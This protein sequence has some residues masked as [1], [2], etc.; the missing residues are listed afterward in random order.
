MNKRSTFHVLFILA[1]GLTL[2]LALFTPT[3][4]HASQSQ[5]D[6]EAWRFD[7]RLF[8]G[9]YLWYSGGWTQ[10]DTGHAVLTAGSIGWRSD[11]MGVYLNYRLGFA[12]LY[13][14]EPDSVFARKAIG[15]S[16]GPR[17]F[18]DEGRYKIWTQVSFAVGLYGHFSMGPEVVANFSYDVF[19]DND[20]FIGLDVTYY[21]GISKF[22]NS[23]MNREAWGATSHIM[24][25]PNFGWFF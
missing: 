7:Y 4:A 24:I 12:T 2:C 22:R 10:G 1:I 6:A 21:V 9:G 5:A 15:A 20:F 25:V 3:G 8:G 13:Y 23:S 17:F 18:L 19:G 16:I 11:W 14:K